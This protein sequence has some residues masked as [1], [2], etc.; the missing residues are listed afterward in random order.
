M[1]GPRLRESVR[2]QK[3]I[4]VVTPFTA[5]RELLRQCFEGVDLGADVLV[6]TAA[7]FQS[8][9]RD[10]IVF[11]FSPV[12]ARGMPVGSARWIT[13]EAPHDVMHELRDKL[14]E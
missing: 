13:L 3:S 7:G 11:V 9:E 8:D 12:V 6:D 1:N 14:S 4:G 5:Q 2:G 10:I